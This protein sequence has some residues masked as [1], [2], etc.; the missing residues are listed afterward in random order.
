LLNNSALLRDLTALVT[1]DPSPQVLTATGIPPHVHHAKLT[2]SCLELCPSTLTEVKKLLSDVRQAVCDAIKAK[3]F[4]NGIVTTQTLTEMLDVHHK[5]MEPLITTRLTALQTTISTPA[6][7]LVNQQQGLD[8]D[9]ELAHGLDDNEL[10]LTLTRIA[11]RSYSHSGC[12]WHTPQHFALPPRMKLDTGWKNWCSGIPCYQVEMNNGVVD[13]RAAPIRPFCDFKNDIMPKHIRRDFNLHWRPIF[14]LMD[15][16]PRLHRDDPNSFDHGMEY[17][18]IRVQ[19]VFGKSKANPTQWEQSTW[20]KHVRHSSIVKHGTESDKAALQSEPTRFNKARSTGKLKRKRKLADN[21]HRC[22]QPPRRQLINTHESEDKTEDNN[23][24][25]G[26]HANG[27]LST[28]TRPTAAAARASTAATR[29][30]MAAA[31]AST[32]ESNAGA[33]LFNSMAA[34]LGLTN[35][36]TIDIDEFRWNQEAAQQELRFA[37]VDEDGNPVMIVRNARRGFGAS[38]RDQNYRDN[39]RSLIQG[40]REKGNCVVA[41]YEHAEMELLHKCDTCKRY[42]HVL[43]MMAKDLLVPEEGGSCDHHYCYLLCKR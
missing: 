26:N 33:N 7:V 14:N 42:V 20:P 37:H 13:P 31:R 18:K 35:Q 10:G 30:S 40:G 23:N 27:D 3:A 43:C 5:Q 38:S 9:F 21:R 36:V 32:D 4:E 17:L 22:W 12:F 8:D 25:E 34:A 41:N 19:Y 11:Y 16:Y 1:L 15:A 29:A 6:V 39:V 28:Q 24:D 2:K